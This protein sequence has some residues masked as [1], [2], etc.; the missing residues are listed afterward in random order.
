MMNPEPEPPRRGS[1]NPRKGLSSSPNNPGG[2]P[3]QLDLTVEGGADADEIQASIESRGTP[4]VN[5]R[6]H[7]WLLGG[8]GNDDLGLLVADNIVGLNLLVDGGLG[9]NMCTADAKVRVLRCKASPIAAVG[10]W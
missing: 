6:G 3:T 5:L 1:E 2:V 8:Q 9:S 10:K 4:N 7:V